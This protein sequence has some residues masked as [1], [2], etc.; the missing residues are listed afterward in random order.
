MAYTSFGT[1]KALGRRYAIDPALLLESER[2]QQEYNLA[3]GREA[4]GM[5]AS[6]FAQTLAQQEERDKQAGKSGMAGTVLGAAQTGLTTYMLGKQAGLWG[7]G[8]GAVTSGGYN[9]AAQN[10]MG[11]ATPAQEA[12]IQSATQA[13]IYSPTAG[14][15][16]YAAPATI[17]S[18]GAGMASGMGGSGAVAPAGSPVGGGTALGSISSG[19]TAS[20]AAGTGASGGGFPAGST[21]GAGTIAAAVIGGLLTKEGTKGWVDDGGV[22]GYLG[23][24]AQHPVTSVSEPTSILTDTGLVEKDTLVGKISGAA[25]RI[26]E[27]I[28]DTVMKILGIGGGK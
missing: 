18:A 20:T 21:V 24:A 3:P 1:R 17:D 23:T 25:Q 19:E 15:I 5:Q 4:R 2:L 16:N 14:G 28:V 6:Q 13:G 11:F 7:A 8:Q 10:A 26:E 27:S 9:A 22:K 12:A